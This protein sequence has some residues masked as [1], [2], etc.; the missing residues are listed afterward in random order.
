MVESPQRVGSVAVLGAGTMGQGIAVAAAAAGK[1]VRVYD[2]ED[3]IPVAL[4]AI[5][6]RFTAAAGR[7]PGDS[8]TAAGTL[9]EAVSGTDLVIEAVS[10][11]LAVK[12]ALFTEL[13]GLL[14]PAAILSTNTSS[15]PLDELAG[16]VGAP[17]RFLATHFFNPAELV[18]G[19]EVATTGHTSAAA[20]ATTTAFLTEIG[21][22]PIEVGAGAGFVA[23]RLQLALFCEAVNCVRDGAATPEQVD[24]VV[25]RTFGFR[26]PA[27]GP[28]AVA[29]M[30]GLDVYASILET[31]ER[32]YGPRFATPAELRHLVGGGRL[33]VKT[34]AGFRDYSEEE[35]ADLLASRDE[36][37]RRLLDAA[38]S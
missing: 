30:A 35:V 15:L 24:A 17:D 36:R 18:P 2:R 11:D 12:A 14:P 23:N 28:F 10:E 33:G 34:R 38:G 20:L 22:E 37:Y 13:A 26:L 31:L 6:R 8:V 16:S 29:D 32:A 25:R 1:A 5:A 9:A 21:K 27:F 19:V 3:V 4:Q 7:A